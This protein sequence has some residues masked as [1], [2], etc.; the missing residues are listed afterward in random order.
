[1]SGNQDSSPPEHRPAAPVSGRIGC[2]SV[3][4]VLLGGVLLLPGVCAIIMIAYDWRSVL[5]ASSLPVLLIFF[6][7]AVGGIF[8]IRRGV[9][10][11]RP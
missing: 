5:T 10:G 8:L 6:A 3:L 11:P 4:L 2:L 1:M 9:R 7:I